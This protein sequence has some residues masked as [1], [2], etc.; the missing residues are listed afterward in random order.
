MV[1]R[2]LRW[3][4]AG[5]LTALAVSL[6]LH[7]FAVQ[8]KEDRANRH[9]TA[10][11]VRDLVPHVLQLHLLRPDLD[12]AHMR[13]LL[14]R[15]ME[16][17]DPSRTA[18]VQ[19][20]VDARTKLTDETLQDLAKQIREGRLEF[21]TAWVQQFKDEILA[22]DNEFVANLPKIKD[23]ITAKVDKAEW[24]REKKREDRFPETLEERR[25]RLVLWMNQKYH[26]FRDYLSEEEAF[27]FAQQD[28]KRSRDKWVSFDPVTETPAL[29]MKS[30]MLAMDP[31]SEYMDSKDVE[32]FENSMARGFS[33]IGVQIRGCPL[34]AQVEKV[35]K[36]GPAF[37]SKA[38]DTRD[39]IIQVDDAPVAGMDLSE[40]VKRI[41]GPRGTDVRLV[42]KKAKPTAE[43]KKL[44][45]VT[46]T[47]DT[48]DLTELRV[49]SKKFDTP[50]GAVGQIY[51]A[52]FYPGVSGDV[53]ERIQKLAEDGPLIG[54]ILDLRGNSGGLL[55]EA[56]R[57]AG[58]FITEGPVVAERN[59]LGRKTWL[60]DRDETRVFSGPMVVL[61]NQFSASA[62]E[63]VA[64]SLRDYGR[65]VIVGSSQTHGKG[66]VQRVINLE[67]LVHM[68]GRIKIT[69][70][71]YFLAGGDSVQN[72]GVE[73][74]ITIPGPKL[75]E[76]WLEREQDGA[77]PWAQIPGRLDDE[78]PDYKRYRPWKTKILQKLREKSEK[79]VAAN[80][81]FD[82]FRKQDGDEDGEPLK[83]DKDLAA[84]KANVKEGPDP[85]LDE[86]V[87]IV[88][89]AAAA[90]PQEAA[91]K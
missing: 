49:T 82:V 60:Y 89:D 73:P 71:Q 34:G 38:F 11:Q 31:H 87:K 81:D 4:R 40:I 46:L 10:R 61:V 9:L 28:L 42:L 67:E 6:A 72:K 37:R 62:A 63:I 86:A 29:V 85:Q 25:R 39:Q 59:F 80:K 90:W 45:N 69:F 52:N 68:P 47:R 64:G 12:A 22:R 20:E 66:T 26:L 57:M 33:G 24:E 91:A 35:I 32:Q 5:L 30:L 48:I 58:L 13:L 65:A 70:Q 53:A 1:H 8:A 19:S 55:E 50:S 21:F 75:I 88:E 23:Q 83:E 77:I 15:F 7:G 78:Q 56:V 16:Q 14:K 36:G 43:G 51:V 79:R 27:Q 84:D 41:K 54:L 76:E 2:K 17:V 18:Y 44:S 74:E 3:R